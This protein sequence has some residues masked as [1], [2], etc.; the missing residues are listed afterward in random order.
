MRGKIC[1]LAP[2]SR[3]TGSMVLRPMTST[4]APEITASNI[5]CAVMRFTSSRLPAPK[6]R[7]TTDDVPVPS[8]IAIAP[9][10]KLTGKVKLIAASCSVLTRATKKAPATLF[11]TIASMPRIIGTIREKMALLTEP[12]VSRAPLPG[13]GFIENTDRA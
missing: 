5:A 1:S 11:T 2:S 6:S 7:D 10:M 4:T 3:N 8:A 9:T 13:G 12:S